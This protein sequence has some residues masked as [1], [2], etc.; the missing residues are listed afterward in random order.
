MEKSQK[1]N[2]RRGMFIPESRVQ[3][4][5]TILDYSLTTT[6]NQIL[7]VIDHHIPT[8]VDIGEGILYEGNLNN[9]DFQYLLT[10]SRHCS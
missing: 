6:Y 3:T 7:P 8:L 4:F 1:F 5:K 9:A 2:K 10:S